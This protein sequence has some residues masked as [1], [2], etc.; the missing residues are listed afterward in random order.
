MSVQPG[1][2]LDI[3]AKVLTANPAA[4]LADVAAAAGVGRTTLHNRFPTREA[5]LLALAYDSLDHCAAAFAEA[6]VNAVDANT[7]PDELTAVLTRMVDALIPLG[8]RIDFLLQ[9]PRASADQELLDRIDELDAPLERFVGHAQDAGLIA[10]DLTPWWV[11]A[12]IYSLTYS[13]WD[14]IAAGKLAPLDAGPLTLR[15]LLHGVAP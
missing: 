1:A 11:V 12:T 7:P 9:H 2:I 3:A 8:P 14:G 10:R 15:T 5:L 4:S 6:G 13:A